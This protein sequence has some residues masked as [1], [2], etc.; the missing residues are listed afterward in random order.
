MDIHHTQHTQLQWV[1]RFFPQLL[2]LHGYQ[3]D[4]GRFPRD[5]TI[6]AEPEIAQMLSLGIFYSFG[7]E[8]ADI[9]K[10]GIESA[11]ICKSLCQKSGLGWSG[12]GKFNIGGT[13]LDPH[14]ERFLLSMLRQSPMSCAE[15]M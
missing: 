15:G 8:A 14:Q 13:W 10:S 3:L 2:G 7:S 6:D 11:A 4:G 5:F 12:L 9:C 1:A